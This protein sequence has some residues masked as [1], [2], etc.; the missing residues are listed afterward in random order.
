MDR[1]FNAR[2][3]RRNLIFMERS[4]RVWLAHPT[5]PDIVPHHAAK[6][7]I[8]RGAHLIDFV[9]TLGCPSSKFLRQRAGQMEGGSGSLVDNVTR[10]AVDA[11]SGGLATQVLDLVRRRGPGRIASQSLFP[12]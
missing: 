10:L 6:S 5:A 2:S 3:D 7:T 1:S 9:A 8:V 4:V 12:A 11:A